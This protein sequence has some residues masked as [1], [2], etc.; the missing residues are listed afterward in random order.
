[1]DASA[2]F[3]PIILQLRTLALFLFNYE[4][5]VEMLGVEPRLHA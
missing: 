3:E 1:M 2:G 4:A 5:V